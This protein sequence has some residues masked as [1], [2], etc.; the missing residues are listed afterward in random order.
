ME[1]YLLQ[2]KQ[3]VILT[4]KC[5][6]VKSVHCLRHLQSRVDEMRVSKRGFLF[7]VFA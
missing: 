4:V 3:Y 2:N 7:I 6:L 5:T 1:F